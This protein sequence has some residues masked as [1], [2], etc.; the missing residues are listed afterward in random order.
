MQ[1]YRQKADYTANC[2]PLILAKIDETLEMTTLFLEA[3]VWKKNS[4][5]TGRVEQHPASLEGPNKG[6]PD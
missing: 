6:L 1:N 5:Y 4:R 3:K 2:L